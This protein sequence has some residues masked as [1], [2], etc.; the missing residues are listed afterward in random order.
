MV[1]P[2]LPEAEKVAAIREAMPA[3]TAGIYLNA[4]T[5]GPLARET[6][7][8]M[9]EVEDWELRVGRGDP[10]SRLAFMDRMD[11]CRGVLAAMLSADPDGIGLTHSTTEALNQAIFALDWQPGDRIVTTDAEHPGLLG[12]MWSVRTRSGVEVDV[13]EAEAVE[14]ADEIIERIRASMRP[15]TR[16]IALSQVLWRTG[17]AL[18]IEAIGEIAERHGAWLVVDAAQAVGA[19]VVDAAVLRA[20]VIGFAG[21]KWLCGPTGTGAMWASH[22]ARAEAMASWV[23]LPSFAV[24]DRPTS[25]RLK[26]TGQRFELAD[27]HR[28]SVVGL[29]RAVGWLQ[30]Y[31]GVPW[32]LGRADR[33]A[34]RMADGLSAIEGVSVLTPRERMATLVTF[35]VHGWAGSEVQAELARQ[36]FAVSETID[37][38]D[39]VRLSIGYYNTDEELDR[40]QAAVGEIARHTPGTMPRRPELLVLSADDG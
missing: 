33:L 4:G 31:V 3:T 19:T 8:A 22:R 13:V 12:P 29:A 26:P 27:P 14:S 20:D 2:F 24:V 11:E 23:G 5:T 28:P 18:P 6:V 30:M 17:A 7:A 35:R 38:L 15:R 16:M 25:G 36:V 21:Q 37:D 39:A 32:A 40:V 1:S 34:R 10:D 9:R